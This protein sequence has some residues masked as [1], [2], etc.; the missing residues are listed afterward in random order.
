MN[1]LWSLRLSCC[2]LFNSENILSHLSRLTKNCVIA[3]AT[4]WHFL[5]Q[6]PGKAKHHDAP[7]VV[8]R[9]GPQLISCFFPLHEEVRKIYPQKINP[10]NLQCRWISSSSSRWLQ[11]KHWLPCPSYPWIAHLSEQPLKTLSCKLTVLRYDILAFIIT[12][13]VARFHPIIL[14]SAL[15]APWS[16]WVPQPPH[17]Q[18]I[19]LSRLREVL[20]GKSLWKSVK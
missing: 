4:Q 12:F 20:C 10:G 8:L 1:A 7:G 19:K 14:L 18:R 9:G 13:S 17:I 2:H 6:C 11:S 16:L 3:H 5:F 15:I